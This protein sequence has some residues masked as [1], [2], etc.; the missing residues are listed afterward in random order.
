MGRL[1]FEF[2]KE[3]CDQG[4]TCDVGTLGN[5]YSSEKASATTEANAK[6]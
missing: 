3:H 2:E 5:A 6:Q 1:V 4:K